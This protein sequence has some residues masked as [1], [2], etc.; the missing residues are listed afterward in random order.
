MY[1]FNGKLDYFA[2][3]VP[4]TYKI[5]MKLPKRQDFIKDTTKETIDSEKPIHFL[6][7]HYCDFHEFEG[8]VLSYKVVI[9]GILIDGTKAAV[10]IDG[11]K[12]FIEVE[13][14]DDVI[15]DNFQT[16]V[17]EKLKSQIQKYK[18]EYEFVTL[19]NHMGY[20]MPK[21]W[22]KIS[23]M[24]N[25][26]RHR[27][28]EFIF[29]NNFSYVNNSKELKSISL[30]TGNDDL[31]MMKYYLVVLR[32]SKFNSASWNEIKGYKLDES[33]NIVK[34]KK[35]VSYV[36]RIKLADISR[37]DTT[38]LEKRDIRYKKDF[39][40]D[41]GWDIE[42]S[43]RIFT[44]EVPLPKN[45]ENGDTM[46][47]DSLVFCWKDSKV[48]FLVVN[49][50]TMPTY[51]NPNSWVIICKT[52]F[53]MMM[54]SALILESM[55][56]DFYVA[57]NDGQYDWPF[58]EGVLQY[59]TKLGK[60]IDGDDLDIWFYNKLSILK[61]KEK[62][63]Y[64]R[65]F[66]EEKVKLEAGIDMKQWRFTAFGTLCIDT[67]VL[68]MKLYPKDSKS[69]LNYFL[70]KANL[71]SKEDMP[72][73]VMF[74]VEC[75]LRHMSE[76]CGTRNIEKIEKYLVDHPD[77]T[78]ENEKQYGISQMSSAQLLE[79]I[80]LSKNVVT[81]C[82]VDS[83][84]CHDLLLSKLVISDKREVANLTYTTT[85]DAFYRADGMKV[86]AK[87]IGEK[88]DE[89]F[90]CSNHS[91]SRVTVKDKYPGAYVVAPKKGVYRYHIFEKRL[92][93]KSFRDRYMNES[94]ANR[95]QMQNW[96]L[97][98]AYPKSASFIDALRGTDFNDRYPPTAEELSFNETNDKSDRPISGLDFNSLYPSLMM[99]Y[100]LDTSTCILDY[101]LVKKLLGT[102]NPETGKPYRFIEVNF[103]HGQK[104]IKAW[105]VQH[106]PYMDGKDMKYKGMA[107]EPRILFK[108]FWMRKAVKKELEYWGVGKEYLNKIYAY[109]KG[110]IK[111][112][113]NKEEQL[114]I[115]EEFLSTVENDY[116]KLVDANAT[117]DND[118]NT[119]ANVPNTTTNGSNTKANVPLNAKQ[120]FYLKKKAFI[121]EVREFF[122]KEF[123][124]KD[125]SLEDLDIN[126]I[127]NYG[128]L[129][130]K[131]KAIKVFMN[132]VYGVKGDQNSP[133]FMVQVAGGITTYG[134][135]NIK[136]MK[137]FVESCGCRVIYG[138][139]DSLYIM[140]PEQLFEEMDRLYEEGKIDRLQYWTKMIETTMEFLD[141]F[142][143]KV[144]ARLKE[145][146]GTDLLKM[147]YEEVL[148]PVMFLGKKKYIGIQH[149][150]IV[151]LDI[152][153]N[154][155]GF[156]TSPS[157]FIRGLEIVKRGISPM[158]KVANFDI[159]AETLGLYAKRNMY[160]ISIDILKTLKKREWKLE[161]FIK[162]AKYKKPGI[163]LSTGKL[164]PGNPSVLKFHE[165]M[166]WLEKEKPQIGIKAP[167]VGERFEYIISDV[168][169][170][171]YDI[172][173]KKKDVKAGDK[174]EYPS[175]LKNAKYEEFLGK[176]IEIN[177][178]H[179]VMN[180]VIGT[181]SRLVCQ[182]P[183][184][185][186]YSKEG[187]TSEEYKV[188]DENSLKSASKFLESKYNAEYATKYG[189]TGED[190]KAHYK[191]AVVIMDTVMT[192]KYG[193]SS[194]VYDIIRNNIMNKKKGD[195]KEISNTIDTLNKSAEVRAKYIH[196]TMPI[197][198]LAIAKKC[199]M[200]K[201][202]MSAIMTSVIL[203]RIKNS[204]LKI[205]KLRSRLN[206]IMA[207]LFIE[208][209][210][211]KTVITQII[212]LLSDGKEEEEVNQF[213]DTN[214]ESELIYELYDIYI[215]IV[216]STY[217][218][219]YN[220]SIQSTLNG[221][222]LTNQQ[223]KDL[224]QSLIDRLS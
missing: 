95:L 213:A 40:I 187:M 140:P 76:I 102:I 110:L 65:L 141:A 170:Y 143:L 51:V 86:R 216:A 33:E 32:R 73:D 212:T 74:R 43:S 112:E 82:N 131:Q 184:F 18:A 178:D 224:F 10:I 189:L 191:R 190:E 80:K 31:D 215:E 211:Y 172:Q 115:I 104:E 11:I 7:N 194:E 35:A 55:G 15:P 111:Q 123:K 2:H 145:D 103:M 218:I 83:K 94:E 195:S 56:P 220:K 175:S 37:L 207:K 217:C 6:P 201:L 176:K 158:A 198:I 116:Q 21:P 173:G 63:Q 72:Y 128:N 127:F 130:A 27:A 166:E 57:F 199:K 113:K 105:F 180:E 138:D 54:M 150:G 192:N 183:Q 87:C 117:T 23:F 14:P 89:G 107:T 30:V 90:S 19:R 114:K 120:K 1:T 134:Q 177:I 77:F 137:E 210:K 59:Y 60:K 101:E 135:K 203:D 118:S 200:T 34:C 208:F 8:Y 50:T 165:R 26:M 62:D 122:H 52:M 132:T 75:I 121:K 167:L 5:L 214:A 223:N 188:A 99:T 24:T 58:K 100:N 196:D 206:A 108:L 106:E 78:L 202:K 96:N 84:R 45:I 124:E 156:E 171:Y 49:L 22:L 68:Y 185:D 186:V 129:D 151:N 91:R 163:D 4:G 3:D 88:N 119:T 157:V 142:T 38:E 154:P 70:K 41:C 20:H 147:A 146:N 179:Y 69:S 193:E 153:V 209:D 133:A 28:L 139:T 149:V 219:M 79:T 67:R 85:Y 81:Y 13:I 136:L 168:C 9:C 164:K 126:I 155:K 197:D 169:P 61:N 152:C 93:R 181:I 17:D 29:A 46:F 39:T 222:L 161:D 221:D 160:D 162:T 205:V 44:G 174:Y 71:E 182:Y 66:Q 64:T 109:K 148:F 48:P 16:L 53:D 125:I 42:T 25:Y 97:L 144:N 204:Q 36:F 47:M 12:P 98:M 92:M 159:L